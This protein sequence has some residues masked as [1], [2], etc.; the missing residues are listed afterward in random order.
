MHFFAKPILEIDASMISWLL[1]T[2]RIGNMVRFA[3]NSGYLVIFSC[4]LLASWRI[5]RYAVLGYY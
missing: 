5:S 3:D 4:V 1:G 2:N